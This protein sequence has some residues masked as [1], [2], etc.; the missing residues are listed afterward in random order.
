[1]SKKLTILRRYRFSESEVNMLEFIKKMHRSEPD[2][3]RAA[4]AEKFER[5]FPKSNLNSKVLIWFIYPGITDL[6][7]NKIALIVL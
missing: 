7:K 2:F 5:D 1:M 4:I 3:V 6:I